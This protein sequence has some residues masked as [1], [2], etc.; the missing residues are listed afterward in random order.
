MERY[1]RSDKNIKKSKKKWLILV[2]IIVLLIITVFILAKKCKTIEYTIDGNARYTDEE[3]ISKLVTGKLEEYAP[4]L[5]LKNKM[6]NIEDIPFIDYVDI[7]LTA[8]DSLKIYVYEKTVCGCVEVMGRYMYFDKDGTVTECVMTRDTD[9][10][11]VTGLRFDN[12]LIGEKL[13]IEDEGLFEKILNLSL[14]LKKYECNV[15][16]IHFNSDNGVILYSGENRA[17]MGIHTSYDEEIKALS[18]MLSTAEDRALEYDF[19]YYDSDNK[20]VIAK[21]IN[22]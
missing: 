12:I 7:E 5:Y 19:R 6:G 18:A 8:S 11:L 22:R 4:L 3:I 15:D 16:E 1:R 17:L 10:P 20:K 14:A 13:T 9:I 2:I 21:P